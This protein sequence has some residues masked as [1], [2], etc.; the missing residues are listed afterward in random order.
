MNYFLHL[1]YLMQILLVMVQV[2]ENHLEDHLFLKPLL[3]LIIKQ[4]NFF[5]GQEFK[6]P[7]VINESYLNIQLHLIAS[8]DSECKFGQYDLLQ[9]ENNFHL[10]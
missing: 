7:K 9:T 3:I 1:N 4:L 10:G 5:S 6:E 8:F 2:F